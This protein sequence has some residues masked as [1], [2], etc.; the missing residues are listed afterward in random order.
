[1]NMFFGGGRGRPAKKQMAK[2]KGTKKALDVTLEEI[3]NG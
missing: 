3:Y 1:M 2:V